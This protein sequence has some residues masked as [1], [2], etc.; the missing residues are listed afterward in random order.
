MRTSASA[1]LIPILKTAEPAASIC[2][3]ISAL[4]VMLMNVP[5]P[6][7]K[8]TRLACCLLL[9][10]GLSACATPSAPKAG[11]VDQV[12][13]RSHRCGPSLV[14]RSQALTP[15]QEAQ[16]CSDLG[17]VEQRFHALFGTEG[18]PVPHDGNV[19]LR[20]NIYSSVKEFKLWAGQHFD[21]PV[22]NGGMFLEG[23]P[24][25]PGNQAEFVAYQRDNGIVHNL[26]HEFTH[27]LDS[28]FNLYGDFC[29]NL[30]DSHSP[31]ENCA[32]PSPLRPYLVWWT[33]G[34]AEYVSQG[35]AHPRL[36]ELVQ[37]QKLP[38]SEL[39]NTGYE[40]ESG[41]AR[42]YGSGYLAARYMMERQR[43]RVEQMLALT[44]VGDYPRYQALVRSWGQGMDA[45][46]VAWLTTLGG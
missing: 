12:L 24:D 20:A 31:P 10:M 3:S 2:A 42:I 35:A 41:S 18:K 39:F 21:M 14:L 19:A 40:T 29:A 1:A 4:V 16:I 23:L 36:K 45:D 43:S 7:S 22:D 15:D 17:V 8:P 27:Y 28:R 25:R 34:I 9:L 26:A 33:E 6:T 11:S 44:R 13:A 46:F 37:A 38:L 5:T 30:H 32:Q